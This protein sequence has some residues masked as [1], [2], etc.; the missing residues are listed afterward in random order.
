MSSDQFAFAPFD[1]VVG[2]A[3]TTVDGLAVL[4]TPLMGGFAGAVAIIAFTVAVRLLVSPLTYVQVRAERRRA[5]LAPQLAELRERHSGDPMR[6]ATETMA[7]QRDAGAGM[8]Y[9]VLPALLQAPF[10]MVMYRLVTSPPAGASQGFLAGNLFGVP[11]AVHVTVQAAGPLVFGGLLGLAAVL[12]WWSSRRMRRLQAA[13]PPADGPAATV[14]RL[15]TL[16]PYVTVLV[17]AFVPLG[18]GLYV[19]TSAA[20]T[21]LEQAVWR[22]PAASIRNR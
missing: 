1:A 12:G 18:G 3:H 7:L 14:G 17:V 13:S 20:W 19:V 2:V 11:L 15:L 6:L 9:G 5:A 10:F 21:A 4:L 8:L 16:I 22:R